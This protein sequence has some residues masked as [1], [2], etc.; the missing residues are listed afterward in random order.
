[1]ILGRH[2]NN[3]YIPIALECPNPAQPSRARSRRQ[4]S[5]L[6]PCTRRSQSFTA[7]SWC[8]TTGDVW[9]GVKPSE[10]LKQALRFSKMFQV[11]FQSTTIATSSSQRG[12][13]IKQQY[14]PNCYPLS[15]IFKV[16]IK[17]I[18]HVRTSSRLFRSSSAST[19]A[20]VRIQ[21]H[22]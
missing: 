4:R 9:H 5:A 8:D 22:S 19:W 2:T 20:Q 11:F 13:S 14:N 6:L 12:I 10:T 15:L 17:S 16:A 1:M 21:R 7:P 18:P 3:H